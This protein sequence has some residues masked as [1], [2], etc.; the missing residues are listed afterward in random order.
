[1]TLQQLHYIIAVD[2]YRSFA[3]AAHSLSITQPTLSKMIA[4][5]EDELDVRIFDRSNRHV[6]PTAIGREII[7]QAV[8]AVREA[9]RIAEIVADTRSSL[10]GELNM[11]VGPSIA[12]YILPQFIRIYSEEYPQVALKIEELRPENM[13]EA[14]RAE[15]IDISVCTA[16][17]VREDLLEIPLYTE[18]FRVYL[19][20]TCRQNHATFTPEE[21]SHESMWVMKEAQCL[22]ESAFSFCK[23]RSAGRRVY[24]AGNIETL[25]RVVDANGGFTIIP[26]MHMAL[27]TEAQRKNV[28]PLT[29][30]FR[31]MRRVAMYIR[32][33]YVRER[34]LGSVIAAIKRIV[35]APML[36]PYIRK[37]RIS[38]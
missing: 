8:R 28:R 20:D 18:P 11:A 34:M 30:D 32:R 2:K 23:A 13:F 36:D 1:M 29:G 35:P 24:E 33:D 17:E 19:S 25:V 7:A 14:L 27:L 9:E 37:D 21:L 3:K 22:R 26:E 38:L 12:P 15:R 16:T 5:L 6:S 31:S 4:N 10:S